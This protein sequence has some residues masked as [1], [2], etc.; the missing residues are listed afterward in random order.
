MRLKEQY[1]LKQLENEFPIELEL[2]DHGKFLSLDKIVVPGGMRGKGIGSEVL[3][4]IGEH[5]DK[6]GKRIFLTPSTSY[7]GTSTNRLLNFYQRFGFEKVKDIADKA[8]SKDILVRHPH[9]T[10]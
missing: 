7:G 8:V 2:Y 1:I 6:E 9:S 10:Q 5:A 4:K 3:T